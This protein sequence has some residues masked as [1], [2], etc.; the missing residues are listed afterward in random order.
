MIRMSF[1][2]LKSPKIGE[3]LIIQTFPEKPKTL[4]VN[5][6]YYIYNTN[7]ETV[8]T[9]SSKWC[10]LDAGSHKITRLAP[11]FKKYADSDY[12]SNEPLDDANRKIQAL[13][14]FSS[15]IASSAVFTVQVTDLDR[16]FH[17]NNARYGDMILNACGTDMLKE[18]NLARVDLNFISQ[19]FIGEQYEV[20]K[21]QKGNITFVEARKFGSD[22]VICRSLAEW[23]KRML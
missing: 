2:I 4:D 10:V 5:R 3:T 17:M 13:S 16:N 11:L 23:Q 22:T 6:G 12:I 1:K 9:A 18:N 14:D 20:Y 21:V 7:G 19:L 15:E 8:I